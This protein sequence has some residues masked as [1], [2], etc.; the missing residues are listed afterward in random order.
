MAF[1][2]KEINSEEWTLILSNVTSVTFQNT[3][4]RPFYINFTANDTAPEDEIGLVYGPWQGEL[5]RSIDELSSIGGFI[6]A[7]AI[8]RQ[9]SIIVDE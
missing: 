8:S 6:W 2:K 1:V 3:S 7:K 9:S 4:S 5:N